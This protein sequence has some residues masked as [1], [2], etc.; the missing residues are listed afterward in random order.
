MGTIFVAFGGSEHRSNVLE[1]AV[2]QAAVSDHD[3]FVYH[4]QESEEESVQQIRDEIETVIRRTAPDLTFEVEIDTRG[5]F[6]DRTNVS[7]EKLLTDAILD[8]DRDYEFVV[9][10]DR[11]HD[12]LDD[13]MHSSMTETVL[14]THAIPVML[15]PV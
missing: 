9:M 10:G 2:E 11:E 14:E 13:L 7:E 12:F 5:G 3:L 8:S 1:F 6:S 15:V 4:V